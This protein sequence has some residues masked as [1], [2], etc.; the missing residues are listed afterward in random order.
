MMKRLVFISIL[1]ITSAI[2]SD[3]LSYTKV[4]TNSLVKI[5]CDCDIQVSDMLSVSLDLLSAFSLVDDSLVK[6]ELLK[7]PKPAHADKSFVTLSY[8]F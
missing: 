3:D 1:C 8:K 5:L 6:N 2:A 4:Q 7:S